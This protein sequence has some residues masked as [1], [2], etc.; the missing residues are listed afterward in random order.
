MTWSNISLTDAKNNK[1]KLCSPNSIADVLALTRTCAQ[2]RQLQ[3]PSDAWRL[4]TLHSLHRWKVD[5]LA[6]W[7]ANP[8]GVGSASQL[9]VALDDDFVAPVEAAVV[10]TRFAGRG[11]DQAEKRQMMRAEDDGIADWMDSMGQEW[12]EASARDVFMWW[13]YGEGWRSRR[14]VWYCVVHATTTARDA[15]W[16]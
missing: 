8:M 16:W 12:S 13:R 2:L 1:A 14:R 7:R 11:A 6:R 4:M 10:R 5:L 3:I 15:D 9:W